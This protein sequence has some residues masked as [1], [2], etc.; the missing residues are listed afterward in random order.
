M[1]VAFDEE[2]EPLTPMIRCTSGWGGRPAFQ[3]NGK[4]LPHHHASAAEVK[5]CYRKVRTPG[6]FPCSWLIELPYDDGTTCAVECGALSLETEHGYSCEAG[7]S[8]TDAQYMAEQ[9]L[10]YASDDEEARRLMKAGVQ[11]L[12]M[13]GQ[14]YPL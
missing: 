11:P 3:E 6:G 8:H 9:G 7:H 14:V 5:D 12:T 13:V 10:A 4:G 2:G 1:P